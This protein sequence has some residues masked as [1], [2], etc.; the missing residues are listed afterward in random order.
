MGKLRAFMDA[1]VMIV[2]LQSWWRMM[3]WGKTF[4]EYRKERRYMKRRFFVG[5]KA[6]MTSLRM[7]MHNRVGKPFLAWKAEVEEA[8]RLKF[9]V[10]E[11]FQISIRRLRLTP[12]AVMAFFSPEELGNMITEADLS[13]VRRL[14]LKTLFRGW[15]M[16]V[17]TLRNN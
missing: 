17:R 6:Y 14:L 15:K 3:R 7:A 1:I 10:A 2:R 9:L 16:E 8:K 12:Q 11:F 13:K 4:R 5:W